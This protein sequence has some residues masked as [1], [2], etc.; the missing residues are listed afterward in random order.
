MRGAETI[1]LK[2]NADVDWQG[3]PIGSP[4]APVEIVGCQLWPRE[5]SEDD[6]RGRVILSGWNVYIPPGSGVT[7]LATDVLNIRGVDHQ[8]VGVP[9]HYDYKGR[10]KGTIL[11]ASTTGE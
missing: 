4:P 2:R 10:D 3:D 11:V 1:L 6:D 9:G 7:V 5:S 8:V